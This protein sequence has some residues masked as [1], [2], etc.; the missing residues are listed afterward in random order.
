MHYRDVV[1][2]ATVRDITIGIWSRI[3]SPSGGAG[4]LF[5]QRK[6]A[7]LVQV[8]NRYWRIRDAWFVD[9]RPYRPLCADALPADRLG[10]PVTATMSPTGDMAVNDSRN[11]YAAVA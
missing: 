5:C 2:G 1:A 7:V 9:P 3:R 11:A 4:R 10:L 6:L 8:N